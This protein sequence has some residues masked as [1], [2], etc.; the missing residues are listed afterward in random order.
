[1]PA[2]GQPDEDWI[3]RQA[4]IWAHELGHCL[5]LDD[6]HE[7]S[8]ADHIMYEESYANQ[9][10]LDPDECLHFL[11]PVK[12]GGPFSSSSAHGA[13]L[14]DSGREN[15]LDGSSLGRVELTV[16]RLSQMATQSTFV[17]CGANPIHILGA[18]FEG[19]F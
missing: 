14:I 11:A 4:I 2:P 9:R 13:H 15:P 12:F 16:P 17:R 8:K 19:F 10:E 6:L 18:S 3:T 7:K 1:M 5:D